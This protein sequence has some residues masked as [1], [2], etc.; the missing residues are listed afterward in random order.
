MKRLIKNRILNQDQR[1]VVI[2]IA[3]IFMLFIIM[4]AAIVIDLGSGRSTRRVLASNADLAVLAGASEIGDTYAIEACEEAFR[5]LQL[6]V[7]AFRG[8]ISPCG[9]LPPTCAN[10]PAP[11]T[12]TPPSTPP[13]PATQPKDVTVTAGDYT[14]TFRHPV[15]DADI[16]KPSVPYPSNRDGVQCERLRLTLSHRNTTFF[17][18]VFGTST[19][20]PKASATVRARPISSDLVP[21]LWL[22][23]PV[24]CPVLKAA[25]GAKV[26]VGTN[27]NPGVISLDSDTSQC[28]SGYAIDIANSSEAHAIPSAGALRGSINLFSMLPQATA[29]GPRDCDQSKVGSQINIQPIGQ[30]RR[31]TRAPVDHRFNCK[32][33]YPYYRGLVPI[34]DCKNAGEDTASVDRLRSLVG[35]DPANPKTVQTS[36]VPPGFTRLS[37]CNFSGNVVLH[38]NTWIPCGVKLTGGSSLTIYGNV[39]VDGEITV[40]PNSTFAVRPAVDAPPLAG[41]CLHTVT[42]ECASKTGANAAYLFQRTPGEQLSSSGTINFQNTTVLQNFGTLNITGGTPL[43]SAPTEGPFTGLALW[44]EGSLSSKPP[45]GKIVGGGAMAISG[46]FFAPDAEFSI[47]GGGS[48]NQHDAQFISYR[49]EVTGS[50][51]LHLSP[52]PLTAVQLEVPKAY[53]IR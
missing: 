38:G 34:R 25:G 32:R 8:T 46:T 11:T 50:G 23:D 43:W 20:T 36:V 10:P 19:L 35:I 2:V 40:N 1:G 33:G 3:A 28:S 53:L 30:Q 12:S 52:N 9:D 7:A 24:G 4:I 48:G 22:L 49:L 37:N 15:S 14:A 47:S 16:Y 13:A 44:S 39:I 26:H 17:A 27:T 42:S 5:F 29:C 45:A 51:V 41:T 21:S 18:N 6:N 31:A